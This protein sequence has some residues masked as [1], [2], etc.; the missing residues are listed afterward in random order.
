MSYKQLALQPFSELT[1][2]QVQVVRKYGASNCWPDESYSF[3]TIPERIFLDD[4]AP[5]SALLRE[6]RT[7]CQDI[8]VSQFPI[9]S[10]G[11]GPYGP[12]GEEA[13]ARAAFNYL[14]AIEDDIDRVMALALLSVPRLAVHLLQSDT[15]F[16][17]VKCRRALYEGAL[18]GRVLFPLQ[19]FAVASPADNDGP[20]LMDLD[21]PADAHVNAHFQE[22]HADHAHVGALHV[23]HSAVAAPAGF[24]EH[25]E[26]DVEHSAAAL[27]GHGMVRTFSGTHSN[28]GTSV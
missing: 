20:D 22:S 3:Q 8:A 24:Q 15:G 21:P 10:R 14:L 4:D 18:Y 9:D 5:G 2:A 27:A 11:A 16:E 23:A 28:V 12:R 13:I 1:A 6:L 19:P 25:D 26:Q 7:A 17:T